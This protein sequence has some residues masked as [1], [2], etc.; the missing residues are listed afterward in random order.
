MSVRVVTFST[1]LALSLITAA[2]LQYMYT[3]VCYYTP[4]ELLKQQLKLCAAEGLRTLNACVEE[5]SG[6]VI[7]YI[8][9]SSNGFTSVSACAVVYGEKVCVSLYV[10]ARVCRVWDCGDYVCVEIELESDAGATCI[11]DANATFVEEGLGRYVI[12]LNST[13]VKI[14][15]CRGLVTVLCIRR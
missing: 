3:P 1:I 15:E 8:V 5:F 11:L 12:Y 4:R 14:V 7:S 13:C 2:T 9:N 6:H 10:S